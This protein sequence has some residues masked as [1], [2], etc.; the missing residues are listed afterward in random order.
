VPQRVLDLMHANHPIFGYTPNPNSVL[1][2]R[3]GVAPLQQFAVNT[4]TSLIQD[5]E[6]QNF[7][8]E[9]GTQ[10][11][12]RAQDGVTAWMKDHWGYL[13]AVGAGLVGLNYLVMVAAV[14]PTVRQRR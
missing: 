6:I 10:C 1:E 5:P 13:V 3:Y 14:L 4:V 2:H 11:Q 12:V 8:A 9:V 7:V